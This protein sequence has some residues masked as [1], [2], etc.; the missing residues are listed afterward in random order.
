MIGPI[1]GAATIPK[2]TRESLRLSVDEYRG[3]VL[4][5]ARLWFRP[6]AGGDDR[7]G[8][9]GWAIAIERLPD[10]VAE[11]RRIEAAARKAGLLP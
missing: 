3:H 10:I 9:E 4:L 11:L 6:A 5:N 8:R 1:I 7:P 2:N